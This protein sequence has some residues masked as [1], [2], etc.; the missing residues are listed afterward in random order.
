MLPVSIRRRTPRTPA[1][2]RG[3]TDLHH[4]QRI[5]ARFLGAGLVG[6][7]AVTWPGLVASASATAPWWPP[8]SVILAIGP[9]VALCGASFCRGTAW[10]RPLAVACSIGYLTAVGLWFVAWNGVVGLDFTVW[11]VTF[12]GMAAMVLMLVRE[13]WAVAHLMVSVCAVGVAQ[14]YGRFGHITDALVFEIVW[15]VG[16]TGV[17]MAIVAV[18]MR[19]AALLDETRAGA[20]RMAAESA[21]IAARGAEQARFDAVIH[22]RAIASLLAVDVGVPDARLMVQ[23]RSAL[24]AIDA[25]ADGTASATRSTVSGRIAL[26]RIRAAAAEFGDDIDV[27]VVG[28]DEPADYP[29]DA[30]DAVVEAMGEALRNVARHAGPDASCAVLCRADPDTVSMAVVDDGAG[31]DPEAIPE[32]RLGVRVGITGR[33]AV[34]PGGSAVIRSSRGRGATVQIAWTRP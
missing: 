10:L 3:D 13:Q 25:L 1:A 26:R 7:L 12:P 17:F 8:I 23:A 24:D 9:G 2:G 16:F 18:A 20:Y 11:L 33:M 4:V 5:G 19:T 29:A 6:Y 31:F 15:A 30:V 32:G 28:T 27:D 34:V 22:D 21:A 14:Q